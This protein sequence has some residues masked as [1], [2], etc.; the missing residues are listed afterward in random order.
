[1]AIRMA[2]NSGTRMPL[3]CSNCGA[4]LVPLVWISDEY[5]KGVVVLCQSC[6]QSASEIMRNASA[7]EKKEGE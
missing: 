2:R 3:R 1:M 5:D 6:L 7:I 4:V